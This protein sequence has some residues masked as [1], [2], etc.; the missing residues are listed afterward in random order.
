[1]RRAIMKFKLP[2]VRK[3]GLFALSCMFL[4][5]F[6]PLKVTAAISSLSTR[7]LTAGAPITI[8]GTIDKGEDLYVVIAGGQYFKASKMTGYKNTK[9]V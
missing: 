5:S 3:R 2:T 6:L 7:K 1:M 8:S 9:S 4:A